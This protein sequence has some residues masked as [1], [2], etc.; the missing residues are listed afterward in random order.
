MSCHIVYYK[1]FAVCYEN[2]LYRISG[3]TSLAYL[4][5]AEAIKEVDR[6]D[7]LGK[8]DIKFEN[9]TE[10]KERLNKI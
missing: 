10:K 4:S 5:M 6:I 1:G 8:E 9:L 7:N 2:G 3:L